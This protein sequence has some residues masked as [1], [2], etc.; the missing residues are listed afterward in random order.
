MPIWHLAPCL[1]SIH[2][3]V[4]MEMECWTSY[5]CFKASMVSYSFIVFF[6][7]TLGKVEE[8]VED[9]NGKDRSPRGHG[10]YSAEVDHQIR[11]P[12]GHAEV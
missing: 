6:F 1:H 9:W 5:L 8:S 4:F 3:G 11:G 10:G 7:P 12:Y 2:K